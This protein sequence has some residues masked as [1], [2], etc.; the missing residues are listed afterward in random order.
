MTHYVQA[1]THTNTYIYTYSEGGEGLNINCIEQLQE[2]IWN[3]IV[4]KKF[5]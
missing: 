1:E 3:I 5:L 4:A 2:V